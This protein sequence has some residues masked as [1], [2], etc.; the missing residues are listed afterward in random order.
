MSESEA[1]YERRCSFDQV[2]LDLAQHLEAVFIGEPK[3]LRV[4]KAQIAITD[5]L[6]A[7]TAAPRIRHIDEWHE[8][9]W[10]VL[11]WH[12]GEAPW[13]GT[14]LRSDWPG[15]HEWWTPLPDW[16]TVPTPSPSAQ[17]AGA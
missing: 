6:M 4:T 8:D 1:D 12:E 2:A 16:P 10:D 7:K 13:A 14:P 11:W 5:L 17:E 9:D 15:Y 3:Y